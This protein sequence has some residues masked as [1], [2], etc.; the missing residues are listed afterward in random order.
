[1]SEQPRLIDG[2]PDKIQHIGGGWRITF[3][4][5]TTQDEI[6]CVYPLKTRQYYVRFKIVRG[7]GNPMPY[8][9][10]S[11]RPLTEEEITH[12]EALVAGQ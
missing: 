5:E 8:E 10:I 1:M 12:F 9:T 7:P 4:D 2:I 3:G 11:E 6:G